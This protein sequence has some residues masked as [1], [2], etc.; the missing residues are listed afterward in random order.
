MLDAGVDLL[1][2][3]LVVLFT[4]DFT[5]AQAGALG[6]HFLGLR[7]GTDGGGWQQRQAECLAL[8]LLTFRT[9]GLTDEIVCGQCGE[10]LG[11]RLVR[12]DAG[13]VEQ[14][15]IVGERLGV[16]AC[17]IILVGENSDVVQF[18]ELFHGEGEMLEHLRLESALPFGAERHVQQ[19]A[20]G[21]DGDVIGLGTQRVDHAEAD[22]VV[23]APNVASVDDTGEDGRAVGDT[24]LVY[25][26]EVFVFAFDQVES[27]TVEAEQVDGFVDVGDVAEIGVEQQLDLAVACGQDLGIQ[28]LEQFDVAVFLVEHE[29]WL[30]EL[31]PLGAE[32]GKL[33][34]HLR[35]DGGDV[36][37]QA[38]VELEFLG[39]RVAGE[40]EEG[41]RADEH[42]LGDDAQ[43]FRFVEFV[44]RFGA[45]QVNLR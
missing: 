21:G 14:R 15:L 45:V 20:C 29:I 23:V 7:E 25:G 5:L 32:L 16:T 6:A 8:Q 12:G 11:D 39:L 19:G 31:H 27:D 35:V 24:V 42:R 18:A 34:E 38:A 17:G 36:V 2:D 37:D 33:A 1:L 10:T 40:F 22:S 28:A 4:R 3:E 44:E 13:A 30:V 9:G 26:G 41:V 43:R